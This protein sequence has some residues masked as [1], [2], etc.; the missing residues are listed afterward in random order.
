MFYNLFYEVKLD[1][2]RFKGAILENLVQSKDSPLL[3]KKCNALDGSSKQIDTAFSISNTILIVECKAK[4][5]SFGFFRGEANA[6]N[7]RN[8]FII[9]SL[10][11]VDNKAKWLALN[12]L[13]KNYDIRTFKHIIPV[14]VT[15]FVEYI[16]SLNDWFWLGDRI[17]RVLTPRELKRRISDGTIKKV[18]K[19]TTNIFRIRK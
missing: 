8:E 2:Q 12:P 9:D 10:K 4:G 1:D 13:G 14:V 18:S 7:F 5:K 17:P 15:P 16:P 3:R 6:I 19:T 11:S